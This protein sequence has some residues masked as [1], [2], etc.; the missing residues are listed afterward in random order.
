MWVHSPIQM[1]RGV[2]ETTTP[3][4]TNSQTSTGKRN[5]VLPTVG[6]VVVAVAVAGI[7]WFGVRDASSDSA[8]TIHG[9]WDIADS[10]VYMTLDTD[11]EWRAREGLYGSTFDWGTYTFEG[12]V[13]TLSN[14]EGSY[15]SGA[16]IVSN[17]SFEEN[18]DQLH[19]DFVSDTCT[20]PNSRGVDQVL[21]RYTP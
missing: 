15:C 8:E 10:N 6:L 19:L 11:G 3:S 12:G 20:R 7:W 14:A 9:T 17:A 18:G 13:L 5:W 21:V 16:T 4:D 1:K 2:M